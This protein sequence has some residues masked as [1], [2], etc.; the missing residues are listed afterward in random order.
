M[1]A[2]ARNYGNT[3]LQSVACEFAN[4]LPL[5]E[6]IAAYEAGTP[7]SLTGLEF[8]WQFRSCRG[9]SAELILTTGSGL[10][11]TTAENENGD[12]V[13]VVKFNNVSLSSLNGD[14]IVDFIMKDANG[15]YTLLAHGTATVFNDP[16][17]PTI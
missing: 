14:Y 3:A 17:A 6:M 10:A 16:V 1:T 2:M 8:E 15:E 13:D 7:M 4:N 11:I 9:D 5:N 12:T